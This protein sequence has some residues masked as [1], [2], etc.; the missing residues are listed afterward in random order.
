MK[1]NLYFDPLFKASFLFFLGWSESKITNYL[2]K[3]F[4]YDSDF[5]VCDG[6][7]IEIFEDGAPI[8][9]I[10]IRNKNSIPELA[11]ECVH[12]VNYVLGGKGVK[13]NHEDDEIQA[14]YVESLI[15]FALR[16]K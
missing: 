8:I 5:S 2:K 13:A 15:R 14:Y 4:N 16:V 1:P 3:K 6:K 9:L 12:A 11:H 10:W 7:T